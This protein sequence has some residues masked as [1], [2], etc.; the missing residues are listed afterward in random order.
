M[1]PLFLYLVDVDV[2]VINFMRNFVQKIICKYI[3]NLLNW[4]MIRSYVIF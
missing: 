2:D 4:E 1:V 3:P